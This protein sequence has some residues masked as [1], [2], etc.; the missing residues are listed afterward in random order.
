M[1]RL[2]PGG[3]YQ[4]EANRLSFPVAPDAAT[5]RYAAVLVALLRE[6]VPA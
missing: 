3:T 2:A 5:G 1:R 4:P 6:L